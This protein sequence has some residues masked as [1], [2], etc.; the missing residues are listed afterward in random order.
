M[1]LQFDPNQDDQKQAINVIVD[2]CVP[3]SSRMSTTELK[4]L[5]M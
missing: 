4:N 3:L 1:K 5:Q 2:N